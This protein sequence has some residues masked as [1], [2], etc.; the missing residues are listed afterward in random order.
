M[1]THRCTVVGISADFDATMEVDILR[2]VELEHG[3]DDGEHFVVNLLEGEADAIVSNRAAEKMQERTSVQI[4][5]S[6]SEGLAHAEGAST[7]FMVASG[8]VLSER[9]GHGEPT[10]R[11]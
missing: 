3:E 10:W 6:R 5:L 11:G 1:L 2:L 9:Y 8:G 7:R 4:Y